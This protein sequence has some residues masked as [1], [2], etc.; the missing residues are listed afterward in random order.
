MRATAL[1]CAL[2]A[3]SL[4]ARPAAAASAAVPGT[5]AAAAE[6]PPRGAATLNEALLFVKPEAAT[7]QVLALVR[8]TL[9]ARRITVTQSGTVDG[10]AID[11]LGLIDAHYGAIAR[12]ARA[13]PADLRP[14]AAGRA[15]FLETF[16]ETWDA[17]VA[18]GAVKR[19]AELAATPT[20]LSAQ[21][22]ALERGVDLCK[23]GGGCVKRCCCCY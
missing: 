18:R 16:G 17:A 21:W 11:R 14:S 12:R 5:T 20:E 19:P 4:A 6:A 15:A 8:E 22:H 23:L 7:E 13:A 2:A 9:A 10:P 1:L 3:A